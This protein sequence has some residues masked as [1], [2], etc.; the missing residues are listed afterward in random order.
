MVSNLKK[1][2]EAADFVLFSRR[3]TQKEKLMGQYRE[4]E[5]KIVELNN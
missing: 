5:T 3:D 4:K 2:M 1:V